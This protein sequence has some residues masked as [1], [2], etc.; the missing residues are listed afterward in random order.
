VDA[1]RARLTPLPGD[2]PWIAAIAAAAVLAAGVF[3]L[4][5]YRISPWVLP[6]LLI[7]ALAALVIVSHPAWGLVVAFLATPLEV[8][9]LQLGPTGLSPAEAALAL[10][11]ANWYMRWILR[12]DLEESPG[13]RDLPLF[14][15][16]AA[17]AMGL[18][19]ATE[20]STVAKVL[21]LWITFVGV[22][23]QA[24]ELTS[25]QIRLVLT[26]LAVGVGILGTVG[27]VRYLQSGATSLLGGGTITQARAVG[28]FSDANYYA[29]LLVLGLLPGIALIL[30]GGRRALWLLLP[31]AGGIAGLAFSLSRGAIAGFVLGALL[32]LA[33]QRARWI[34][35]GLAALFTVAT[36]ANANPI[37]RSQQFQTVEQ[38]LSTLS[39]SRLSATTSRPRIWATAVT[40][41]EQHPFFGVGVN[42]FKFEGARHD[43]FEH[44]QVLEN[45]HS[46]PLSLAAETGL[47]GLAAFLAFY[48]QLA[49]RAAR[50]LRT[51]DTAG[52]AIALGLAAALLAFILQGLTVAQIR[53]NV[54]MATF[55]CLAG[56]LTG[57]ADRART[58]G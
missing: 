6:A 45:A 57:L 7:A 37:L 8:F 14:V 44:G 10:V 39:Q 24:R 54:V 25:E 46:I 16:L 1:L 4:S 17:V 52:F 38:R 19:V 29:A 13:P 11:G 2:L 27:A 41:A 34:A 48:G 49:A 32:L 20:P 33:W 36:L 51:A 40:V 3:S 21:L 26:A 55:L 53:V 56:M 5:A 23:F 28:A 31:V 50:A 12:R 9:G 47:I 43:L 30:A 18:I 58:Q 42:Q 15:L 22:F 35:L